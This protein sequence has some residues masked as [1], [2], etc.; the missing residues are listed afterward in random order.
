MSRPGAPSVTGPDL[1]IN[2][3]LPSTIVVVQATM[4]SVPADTSLLVDPEHELLAG[5]ADHRVHEIIAGR[6]LGRRALQRLTSSDVS[7][8]AIMSDPTGAPAWPVGV[9]GS[10]THSNHWC[11]VAVGRQTEFCGIGIDTEPLGPV[12]ESDLAQVIS[13]AERDSVARQL[14]LPGATSAFAAS[15]AETQ[16]FWLLL[17]F[18]A[19]EC[20][21]KALVHPFAELPDWSDIHVELVVATGRWRASVQSRVLNRELAAHPLIIN[22]RSSVTNGHLFSAACIPAE[23]AVPDVAD[24][25]TG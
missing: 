2:A 3:L 20:V 10:I 13:V 25:L 14:Q 23:A 8:L 15:T 9:V 16:G 6:T 17:L 7:N 5:A 19:K 22:G 4:S 12:S 21:R 1:S 18:S 24:K 11:A